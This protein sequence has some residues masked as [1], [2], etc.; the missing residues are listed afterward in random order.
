MLK[1]GK[2]KLFSLDYFL[3]KLFLEYALKIVLDKKKMG[4][5]GDKPS[6]VPRVGSH[7]P[8]HDLTIIPLGPTL[9][10]GSSDL[11]R[12]LQASRFYFCTKIPKE[13]LKVLLQKTFLIAQKWIPYLILLRARVWLLAGWSCR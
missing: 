6:S 5:F 4:W 7:I 13:N 9:L 12:N 2:F 10:R 3:K 1:F 11:T 8:V